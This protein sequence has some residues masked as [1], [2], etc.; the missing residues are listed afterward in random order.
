ML[1][2]HQINLMGEIEMENTDLMGEMGA[3]ELVEGADVPAAVGTVTE[4]DDRK[5]FDTEGN[6]VSKSA[7][8]RE[9]F[10]AANKSRKEISEEN[11]I[12]YRTVY[13]A[14][15][16]MVNDAEP[17]TR[18]RGVVNSKIDVTSD[19]HVVT[20]ADGKTF[21]DGEEAK[22]E[23]VEAIAADTTT[24]DRNTWIKEQVGAGKDR[25]AVAKA[26]G[27][28]YGVIYGLTKEADGTRQK[29]EIE[30]DGT[31]VSR[32][33]Y[34]RMQIAAGKTKAEVAKELD[35]EYSVVW[36]A[37]KQAKTTEE[38]F[39]DAIATLEKFATEVN[40]TSEFAEALETFKL[41][42]IKVPV[43]E[44]VPVVE[45]VPPAV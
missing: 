11:N 27:L 42:T 22:P 10:N 45:E 7:F 2:R 3:T 16:N 17:A 36:Q 38:K 21:L 13:G 37:T 8:I 6:E 23:D 33:E 1:Y 28:S 43:A 15:V 44:A 29:H 34:I 30:V 32:S 24:V 20:T 25:G 14:T 35:V 41:F 31:M 4:Q 18:G 12:P 40:E 26:L 5:W 39:V 19:G 9:Q